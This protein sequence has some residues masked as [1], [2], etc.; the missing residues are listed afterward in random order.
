MHASPKPLPPRP[1]ASSRSR[2]SMMR[3][4]PR[5]FVDMFVER[6]WIGAL[7]GL[8]AVVLLIVFRPH[9][10]PIYR[11]EVSL[12]F[13][14]RK[15]RVL[16]IQEVVDTSLQ[17]ATELNT[18]MEQ[19][20]SKTFADY[21]LAS[22][23]PAETELIQK[24][25]IDPLAPDAP[26]LPVA[27]IV[28]SN[29]SVFARRGAPI[30]GIQVSNRSPEAAALIANRIARRYIDYN[31][32]SASS[33]TNSAIVFL[34][35]QSE[36]TRSQVE[37][38]ETALQL[39]RAKHNLAAI[40]ETQ[41]VVLQ[42]MSSLGTALVT[43]QLDQIDTKSLIE[44]IEEYQRDSRDLLEIPQILASGSVG[45]LHTSL[46]SLLSRRTMLAERYLARHPR[47]KQNDIEIAETRRILAE[48]IAKA[49]A[50]LRARDEVAGQYVRRLQ[51]E[52]V[53]SEAQARELDKIS[54]RY[55]FLEQD[56]NAKRATYARIVDRL[57]EATITS[58]M[59]NTNIAIFDPAWVPDAPSETGAVEIAAKA[60]AAGL[61]LLFL[62]PLGIGLLDTRLRTPAQVEDSLQEPLLGVVKKMPQLGESER[63]QV[64][65]L[66]KNRD[67]AEAYRGIFSEIEMRST[68]GFPKAMIITSSIPAEGKSL[69][70]SNL[71]AVFASHK[72]R[73]LLV[74]CD[75]R[76]PTLH[77]YFN[78]KP[79]VGWVDW[80]ETDAASRPE[81]P[82]GIIPIGD[83]LDLLPAG[84]GA[85]RPT[86]LLDQLGH[87]DTL[88]PLFKHYDLVLFDTP[89]AAI[90][91]DA[92]LLARCCHEMIYVCRYRT[93]RSAVVRKVLDRFHEADVTV[94]GVVLNQL[95]ESKARDYGYHGYGT[96]SADY[97]QAYEE[98]AT[99]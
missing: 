97:Y 69:L 31:L 78:L 3:R 75:L 28:Q 88:Y 23:T 4:T 50:D 77:R 38:A 15:D 8:V 87:R 49:I 80:L 66:Q 84:R 90:F 54:V 72:R 10:E 47:M 25:Y 42:K 65:R 48:S 82:E 56:A 60:S 41:N 94:L 6:W 32:D 95:P 99:A 36:E 52:M 34:R 24:P 71:A 73:T 63:A 45:T 62:L 37:A 39:Y 55:K 85:A 21:V 70:S 11:T 29:F 19:L 35:N 61:G 86:E 20:R 14:S 13:E 79:S 59:A 93:V 2:Q 5:D 7:A 12:L 9:F 51:T 83:H 68:L 64:F 74:D 92:L 43:A 89:P 81:L 91:P 16:N 44:K 46:V 53:G 18:H 1:S 22:F 58:Q 76:R 67:I 98:K 27:H 30:L 96:Q 57:T 40:G 26:L 33:R 17:T